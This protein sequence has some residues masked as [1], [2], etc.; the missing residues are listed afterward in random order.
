M[1]ENPYKSPETPLEKLGT[2]PRPIKR[3]W[4]WLMPTAAAIPLG[5]FGFEMLDMA[6]NESWMP[7]YHFLVAGIS[8]SIA[9]GLV[10]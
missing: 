4:W 1:P 6:L 9:M 2:K 5:I 7:T 3:S 8:L 10:A